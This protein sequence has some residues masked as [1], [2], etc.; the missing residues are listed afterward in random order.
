MEKK[1]KIALYGYGHVGKRMSESF[2]LY[3]GGEYVVTAIFDKTPAGKKDIFWNLPIQH[4]DRIKSEYEKGMFESVMICIKDRLTRISVNSWLDGLGVP[5]FFPGRKEDFA[6]AGNFLQDEH[7]EIT[8]RRDHYRFH[9][10]R[11]MLGALSRI[12]R[13]AV[14]FLFNEEGK[15]NIDNYRKYMSYFT[16]YLLSYPFRLKD[17]VP[18]KVFMKGSYCLIAK[19]YSGNYWHFTM[20]IADCVYLMET[21]GYRGKYIYYKQEFADELLQMLGITP[22]RLLCMT[23]LDFDKVYVFEK[24]YDINHDDLGEMVYSKDVLPEMAGQ[25]RSQL[26]RDECLPKR[27]YVKRIGVRK[28]LNGENIAAENGFTVMIPEEHSLWEQMELFYNADIILCPH[29]ANSTNFLY[30]HKGAFFVEIFS[31][32]WNMMAIN[33]PACEACG[34]HYLRL[35]GHANETET[36]MDRIADY[37]VDEESLI[38][39]IKEAERFVG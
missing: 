5:V 9:V 24:L 34:V 13:Y 25:I 26:T 37:S 20:E 6:E 15:I 7:P 18:E 11:N 10:Y 35:T 21:A 38:R 12:D 29:G 4:S 8:V 32:K 31:D 39:L 33:A 16:P 17:P 2:R 22:D 3:W 14:L 28:L 23:D 19:T 30:M 36:K 27:L 1:R